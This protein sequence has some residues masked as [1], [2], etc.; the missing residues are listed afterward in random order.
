MG[1][2]PQPMWDSHNPPPIGAQRPRWHS[3]LSPINVGPHQIYPPSGLSVLTG[4]P[5]RVYP[6]RGTTSSLAH[7]P[8]F[9]SDTICNG[10]GPPLVYIVLF[11]LSLTGFPLRAFPQGFKT[12]L[13]GKGFHNLIKGVLFSFPTNVGLCPQPMWDSHTGLEFYGAFFIRWENLFTR[14]LNMIIL[15]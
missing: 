8:V 5:P 13:L 15:S 9:G 7:S 1:L 11:G 3:F 14:E 10:S 6:L 2:C 12:R 4:I